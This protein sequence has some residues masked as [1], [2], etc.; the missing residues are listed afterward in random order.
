MPTG[1]AKAIKQQVNGTKQALLDLEGVLW[2]SL[3][4][5]AFPVTAKCLHVTIYYSVS[6]SQDTLSLGAGESVMPQTVQSAWSQACKRWQWQQLIG[7]VYRG[8]VINGL[9]S[10]TGVHR[11]GEW[12]VL[13]G[14]NQGSQCGAS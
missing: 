11:E 12:E 14:V 10:L 7:H 6:S 9:V 1:Q 4:A 5:K 13:K 8:R 3:L 2:Y